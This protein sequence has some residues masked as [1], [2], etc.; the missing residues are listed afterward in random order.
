ML[1]IMNIQYNEEVP[2]LYV[3]VYCTD[4]IVVVIFN[5]RRRKYQLLVQICKCTTALAVSD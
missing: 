4:V 1:I 5:E 2:E 3:S